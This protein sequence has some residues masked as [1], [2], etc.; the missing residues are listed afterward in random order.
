MSAPRD[1]EQTE[2]ALALV[3][4]LFRLWYCKCLL[5]DCPYEK[6][7]EQLVQQYERRWGRPPGL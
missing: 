5:E 3:E 1:L 7:M 2:D 6:E 4:A